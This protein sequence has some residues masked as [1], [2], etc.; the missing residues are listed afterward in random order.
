M[1]E[2]DAPLVR[3]NNVFVMLKESTIVSLGR[4]TLLVCTVFYAMLAVAGCS[5]SEETG[6]SRNADQ[7]EQVGP[8]VNDQQPDPADQ[9]FQVDDENGSQTQVPAVVDPTVQRG[10]DTVR[11]ATQRVSRSQI[12]RLPLVKP[13]NAMYTVQVGAY[14]RAPNALVLQKSL[15]SEHGEQ[16]VFN[17]FTST[18]G[19]YRVTIG[20]F[21]TLREA[22]NYRNKLAEEHPK[23]YEACWVTYIER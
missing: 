12:Q 9:S 19:I 4:T 16:P 15:K 23:R 17:L 22:T 7:Q 8:I 14:K 5:S 3:R 1:Y 10:R 2:S 6:A 11:A 18:D 20:K 13:P 21:E